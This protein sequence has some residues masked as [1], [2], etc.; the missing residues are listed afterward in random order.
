MNFCQVPFFIS[1]EDRQVYINPAV[2]D[3]VF[4]V[5]VLKYTKK[6]FKHSTRQDSRISRMKTI[7]MPRETTTATLL[8]LVWSNSSVMMDVG[9][10]RIQY[11]SS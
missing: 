5:E 4:R 2:A 9:M 6:S 7:M 8:D 10:T 11:E 3:R 1:P